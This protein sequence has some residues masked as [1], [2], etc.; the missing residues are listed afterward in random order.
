M[1]TL[2]RDFVDSIIGDEIKKINEYSKY[3][4]EQISMKEARVYLEK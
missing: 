2:L 4:N 1:G 3:L